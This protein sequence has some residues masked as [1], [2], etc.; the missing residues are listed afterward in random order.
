MFAS[1]KEILLR[2][3]PHSIPRG[4]PGWDVETQRL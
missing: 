2:G 4:M 1:R 3:V